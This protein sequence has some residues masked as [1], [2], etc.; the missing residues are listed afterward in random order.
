MMIAQ[1]IQESMTLM[2]RYAGWGAVLLVLAFIAW[3]DVYKD[4]QRQKQDLKRDELQQA[5][6]DAS[7]KMLSHAFEK[8]GTAVDTLAAVERQNS[9]DHA[10][11]IK[12]LSR[13][14]QKKG[15]R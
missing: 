15:G 13:I 1:M 11:I 5:R 9:I 8:L 7:D 6:N 2:E 4:K 12:S 14:E 3:R 10:E